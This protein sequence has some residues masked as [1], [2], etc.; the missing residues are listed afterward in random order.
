MVASRIVEFLDDLVEEIDVLKVTEGGGNCDCPVSGVRCLAGVHGDLPLPDTEQRDRMVFS[1]DRWWTT[2]TPSQNRKS[3]LG[4][5]ICLRRSRESFGRRQ[6][7]H[8]G[9][10]FPVLLLHQVWF[11]L[12]APWSKG[13]NTPVRDTSESDKAAVGVHWR[14]RL[15]PLVFSSS[16]SLS[17]LLRLGMDVLCLFHVT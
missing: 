11:H 15:L 4:A 16:T 9:W 6:R 8:K 2:E 12:S 17:F 13:M 1:G 14:R 5:G 7:A 3:V 10:R